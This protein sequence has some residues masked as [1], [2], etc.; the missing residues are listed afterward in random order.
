[1]SKIMVVE[2]DPTTLKLLIF[3]L[4]RKKY[5]VVSCVNG[6]EAVETVE[7]ELPDLILMDVML[8]KMDGIEATMN[9]KE[10][11]STSHIPIMIL[12]ALGQEMEV[13]KGLQLGAEGYVV[14]PFD[15]QSLLRQIAEKFSEISKTKTICRFV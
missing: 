11:P 2:D 9:I 6:F 4:E 14:K 13:M 1:M 5:E 15:S 7:K 3:M 10:N 12:S 8:P